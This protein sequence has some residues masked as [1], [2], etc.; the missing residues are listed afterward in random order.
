MQNMTATAESNPLF[1]LSTSARRCAEL[2]AMAMRDVNQTLLASASGT[3]QAAHRQNL[4]EIHKTAY[5]YEPDKFS[6]P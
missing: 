2:T 5:F 1:V 6:Q 3:P 4:A